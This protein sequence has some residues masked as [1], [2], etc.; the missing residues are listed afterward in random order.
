MFEVVGKEIAS[1]L[2]RAPDD[3]SSFVF[4]PGDNVIGGG[5]VDELIGFGEEWSWDGLVRVQRK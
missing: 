4:A 1:E 5:I 3:E 2:G